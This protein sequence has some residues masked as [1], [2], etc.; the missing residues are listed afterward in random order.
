VRPGTL[1]APSRTRSTTPTAATTAREQQWE[2]LQQARRARETLESVRDQQLRVYQKEAL[3]REQRSQ[4]DLFLM[5]REYL[6]RG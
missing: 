3:R 6:R 4:D 5:R 2:L 1:A